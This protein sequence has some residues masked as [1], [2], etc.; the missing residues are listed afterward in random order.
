MGSGGTAPFILN[1]GTYESQWLGLCLCIFATEERTPVLNR[2]DPDPVFAVLY[3]EM[4][5]QTNFLIIIH[6]Q[7]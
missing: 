2:Q 1:F 7:N 6:F 5:C 4:L 3:M